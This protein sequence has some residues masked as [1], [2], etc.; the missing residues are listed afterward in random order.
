MATDFETDIP[1]EMPAF[2]RI[3]A[4]SIDELYCALDDL[5]LD[6]DRILKLH[7][8][9]H[10]VREIYMGLLRWQ[11]MKMDMQLKLLSTLR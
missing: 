1:R 4:C 7:L 11:L 10:Q 5:G 6:M 2:R 3:D 8:T 9:L